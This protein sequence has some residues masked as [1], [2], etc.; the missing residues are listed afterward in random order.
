MDRVLNT[1]LLSHPAN[2]FIVW[3][4]L[5]FAMFAFTLV[6]EKTGL[7]LPSME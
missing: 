1:A 2:W 6:S 3:T 5:L 4:T 7:H